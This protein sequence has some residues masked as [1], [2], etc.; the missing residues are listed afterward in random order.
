M[1]RIQRDTAVYIGIVLTCVAML[2]WII[3]LYSPP[4]PGY[5]A[6]P[7]LVP[8]VAVGVMLVM[9][10]LALVRNGFAWWWGR[11]RSAEESQ[12]PDE[13]QSG[14]FTQVGRARLG[15]LARLMIPCALLIPA[16]DWIGFIAASLLFM[17]VIQFV[18]GRREPVK[19][20]VLAVATVGVMYVAMRYG[21]NVPIP[22]A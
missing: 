13:A 11:T 9:A 22:G 4:Y 14:G 20:V 6:S 16:F 12:Y 15:H 2:A 5:G 3:P 1:T 21:F 8:N 19:A 10:I 7:A 17:L 18:I